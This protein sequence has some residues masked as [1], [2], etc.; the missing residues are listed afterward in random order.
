VKKR[1]KNALAS[2]SVER[3]RRTAAISTPDSEVGR[4]PAS[5]LWQPTCLTVKDVSQTVGKC[6]DGDNSNDARSGAI[7]VLSAV[8]HLGNWYR[9]LFD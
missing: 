2:E 6:A 9:W 7:K 5:V 1:P 8:K 4:S 3:G